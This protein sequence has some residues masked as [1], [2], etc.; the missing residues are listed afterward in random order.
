MNLK[1]IE[2]DVELAKKRN[3]NAWILSV[4]TLEEWIALTKRQELALSD[5]NLALM[6]QTEL[7]EKL[8]QQA[9]AMQAERDRLAATVDEYDVIIDRRDLFAFLRAAWRDGQD[10]HGEMDE[11]E[12]WSKASDYANKEMDGWRTMRQAMAAPQQHVKPL[13]RAITVYRKGEPSPMPV[14]LF[15]VEPKNGQ[16]I[17]TDRI[18]E[19][20]LHELHAKY[21]QQHAQA[22]HQWR[23]PYAANWYDGHPDNEDG[24]GPY[25]VRTLYMQQHAQAALSDI[26][27]PITVPRGLIG[28]ACS[29]I[30]KKRDAPKVLAQLRRYTVGDLS[31][32]QPAAASADSRANGNA[33]PAVQV[34]DERAA[35]EAWE[36]ARTTRNFARQGDNGPYLGALVQ[37]AWEAWQARAALTKGQK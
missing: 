20:L 33:A 29:A 1:Q 37:S 2:D 15:G 31:S 17:K 4:D 25:E 11:V 13:A 18:G 12:R 22:V 32:Q 16:M 8:R 3:V 23:K 14:D 9:E 7:A 24:G 19:Y 10:H 21:P 5:A 28:A 35:F 34:L 27:D 30:D 36:R 6:E 26:E